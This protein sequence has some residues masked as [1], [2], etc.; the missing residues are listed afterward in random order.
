DRGTVERYGGYLRRTLEEFTRSLGQPA[1]AVPMIGEAERHRIIVTFNET[2]VAFASD[3]C[4]H[5]LFEAQV[6]DF[7][8]APAI[9]H[10]QECISYGELNEC[11]N[12][13]A[14]Y[15]RNLGAAGPDVPVGICVNRSSQMIVGLLAVLKA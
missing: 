6:A 8:Q 10:E 15:L 11:A 13:L 5:E 12:R 14:H 4:I 9:I 3:R 1:M 2:A 7:P